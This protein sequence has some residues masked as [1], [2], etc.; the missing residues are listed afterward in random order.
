M[1]QSRTMTPNDDDGASSSSDEDN[2]KMPSDIAKTLVNE[3]KY[4]VF[5][6]AL[7]QLVS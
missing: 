1:I 3:K 4:M 7:C 6:L 5:E 2:I